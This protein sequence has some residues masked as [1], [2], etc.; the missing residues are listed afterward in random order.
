MSRQGI[1]DYVVTF[2]KPGDNPE[3]VTHTNESFPVSVWQNY[4]SPIWM[5]INPSDTLQ[6]QSAR[7]HDDERH[8]CPLQLQVIQRCI[9]LWTNPDDIVFDPFGGIGSTLYQAVIMGRRG[10]GNELK[11][12]YYKQACKNLHKADKLAIAPK[13]VGL[14][15]SFACPTQQ[16]IDEV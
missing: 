7:E 3:P 12:S 9:D 13:Q 16:C 10:L 5:D 11:E 1:P 8:I 14:N 2:R 4:A 6:K 15:Y